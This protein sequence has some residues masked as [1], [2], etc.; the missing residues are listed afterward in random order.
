[1]AFD[2]GRIVRSVALPVARR[3]AN[4]TVCDI[5]HTPAI[6]QSLYGATVDG[7]SVTRQ[8]IV[9]NATK[10]VRRSDGTEV[11]SSHKLTFLDNVPIAEA[12]RLV[13]PGNVTGPILEIKGL[14][15]PEGGTFLTEV[16]LGLNA[17]LT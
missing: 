4:G 10:V 9:E 11:M 16:W 13:L 3:M 5:V 7:T 1:M 8:A 6:G 17:G 12:D 14:Q 15:D 2:L